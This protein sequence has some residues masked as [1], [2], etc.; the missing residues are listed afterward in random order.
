M[1]NKELI[2]EIRAGNREAFDYMCG[3]YYT[4]L[5]SY[6]RLLVGDSWA[7]DIVQDVFLKVWDRRATISVSDSLRPYLLRAIYNRALNS[8]RGASYR[9]QYRNE[10]AERIERLSAQTYDPDANEVIR[11]L[12]LKDDMA[13][14]EDVVRL[15]PDRCCQIFRMSYIN[16]LSHKEIALRLGISVS[17]VDN[18]I[19]K[20]LKVLRENLSD[21]RIYMM[22]LF[23]LFLR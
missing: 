21:P 12:Y 22:I 14:I 11:K 23:S 4:P 18:H 1:D 19:Y 7:Q 10:Y 20:A 15:L 2:T 6:A 9:Q 17:T 3:L 16:G 8:I 13:A 5:M